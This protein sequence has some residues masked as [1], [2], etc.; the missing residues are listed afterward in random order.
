MRAQAKKE[1]ITVR[2]KTAHLHAVRFI[3]VFFA[4][5]TAVL[6]FVLREHI[7]YA[8]LLC[9]PFDLP[10]LA[11]WLYYETWKM[12]LVSSPLVIR[13]RVFFTEKAFP[14][15]EIKYAVRIFVRARVRIKIYL[16]NGK[17]MCFY[18]DDKNAWKAERFLLQRISFRIIK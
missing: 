14:Y 2:K 12:T 6:L 17:S 7:F 11:L 10:V 1:K 15:Y 5:A 13:K 8:F 18:A 9:L 16:K 3:S 4:A